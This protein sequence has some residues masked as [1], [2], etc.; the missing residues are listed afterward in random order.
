MK[1]IILLFFKNFYNKISDKKRSS[2]EYLNKDL[3]LF[4]RIEQMEKEK[5]FSS[6]IKYDGI[7]LFKDFYKFC[8]DWLN[9]EMGLNIS[10][11]EYKE[12]IK[13]NSKD[14][15]VKGTGTRKITDYF[16]FEVGVK[17]RI[18]N[19]V[20]IEIEQNKIRIK[21]N[22]GSVGVKVDG[23]LIRDWQGKFEGDAIRKFLRGVYEKW[24]ITSRIDQMEE[25][26]IGD[27]D[28]FLAQ[29]KAYLDLEG[30]H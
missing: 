30:K 27:C 28:E 12:K 15:E 19:L 16:K 3:F 17:F 22:K 5:I 11:D 2:E 9:E 25:K 14:I 21:M 6:K 18:I 23:T 7:F 20:N 26:L 13:G 29:A 10:E 24:I 4:K 8:Y 1:R